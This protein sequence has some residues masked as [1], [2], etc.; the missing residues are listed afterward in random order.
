MAP[1]IE[2]GS[3]EVRFGRR[4]ILRGLDGAFSGRAI[5]L[6]GPNGAGKSTLIHTLLGFVTPWAG[7]AR[8]L[9]L[10]VRGKA[11]ELRS[12]TGYM[13]EN[14]A[15]VAGMSGVRFVRLMAELSGLPV[16]AAMERTHEAFFYVGLGEARYRALGTYSTGMKQMVKLAQAIAHGPRL[17]L[18]DEPTNGLDPPARDRM[19]H[20]IREIRDTGQARL[21]ISSHL[22]RDIEETCDQVL[23]LKDGRI[24]AFCDLER[25]R[26]TN[27]RWVELETRG[28][29]A[30][31]HEEVSRLGCEAAWSANGRGRLI[32]PDGTGT[33]PLYEIAARHNVQLVRLNYKRDSLEEIFLK[34]MG[35]GNG[36]S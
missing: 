19:I 24:A 21:L 26:R 1:V 34:A 31:F 14:D 8:L 28:A 10:D 35:E 13:P 32:L 23:I 15:F 9:G 36:G 22:L 29:G 30:A 33:R 12:I 3:L 20:L 6:L 17:L 25:E 4:T 2:L 16:E 27:R 18:L 11:R 5:G 7:T